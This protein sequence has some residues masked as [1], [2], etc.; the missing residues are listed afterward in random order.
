MS[1][2]MLKI[3]TVVAPPIFGLM[4]CQ[5]AAFADVS[6]VF[7]GVYD[8]SA[9][10]GGVYDSPYVL[11]INGTKTLAICDD[12]L[13]DVASSWSAVQNPLAPLNGQQEFTSAGITDPFSADT[14]ADKLKE[15]DATVQ[16]MYNAASWL[17]VDLFNIVSSD[18]SL[19]QGNDLTNVGLYSYAI[20]QIFDPTAYQ[21]W[22]GGYTLN[23]Q[24]IAGFINGALSQDSAPPPGI[25]IYT[26]DPHSA[27]QEFITLTVPEATAPSLLAFD[28]LAIF[29]GAFLFRRRIAA[30]LVKQPAREVGR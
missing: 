27:S 5:P 8:T 17:A 21:G 25:T 14:A 10:M 30:L 6:M 24:A 13:N 9:Q 3:L 15:S 29:A 18:P 7:D 1:S 11:T 28:L 2:R 16:D 23:N 22:G 26:P 20:W 12:F 4:L 19:T